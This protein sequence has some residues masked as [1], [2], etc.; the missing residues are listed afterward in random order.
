MGCRRAPPAVRDGVSQHGRGRVGT[1]EVEPSRKAMCCRRA[2]PAVRDGVSQHGRGR[3]DTDE[4]EPSRKALGC[5]R[6][7]PA[8]RDG[9]SQH[10]RGRVGIWWWMGALMVADGSANGSGWER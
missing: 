3:V 10:G 1:D 4:V 9:V 6:A 2:P 8:V 5:R 7:P